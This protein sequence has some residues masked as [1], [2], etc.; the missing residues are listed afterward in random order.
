MNNFVTDRQTMVFTV[1]LYQLSPSLIQVPINL[2]F[3]A[4]EMILK[5]I[6]YTTNANHPDFDDNV[7]IWCDLTMDGL[8]TSFP[9]A[10]QFL[11]FCDLHFPLN[12]KNFQTGVATFQFLQTDF[13]V[14]ANPPTPAFHT[15]APN[16]NNPLPLISYQIGNVGGPNTLG[17]LSFTVEFIKYQKMIISN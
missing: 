15:G 1:D 6:S 3:H 2:R 16:F 9:N 8:L 13:F 12:N 7:Q 5:S 10:G 17:K 11:S 4:S 14:P